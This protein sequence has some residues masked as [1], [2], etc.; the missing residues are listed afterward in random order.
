MTRADKSHST[1]QEKMEATINSI[2]SEMEETP[3]L[4]VERI[5]VVVKQRTQNPHEE[6]NEN[7]DE[8]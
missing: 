3:N 2:C 1:I 8:T 5:L 7:I 4:Q 6:L